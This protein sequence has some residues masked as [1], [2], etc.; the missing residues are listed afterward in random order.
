MNADA[1]KRLCMYPK[2][3]RPSRSRG[4]CGNHYT[5]ARKLVESEETTWP[6]LEL[7][8]KCLPAKCMNASDWF[9]SVKPEE[10]DVRK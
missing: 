6:H 9:L 2:C 10:S 4:L 3:K 1:K 5:M 8:G 7:E